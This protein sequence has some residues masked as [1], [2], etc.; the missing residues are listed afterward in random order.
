[1]EKLWACFHEE[2]KHVARGW[3][4]FMKVDSTKRKVEYV[5]EQ[6]NQQDE[7]NDGNILTMELE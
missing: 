3:S 1:M 6:L 5:P 2:L 4:P 7:L